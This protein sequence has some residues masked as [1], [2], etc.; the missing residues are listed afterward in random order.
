MK[1]LITGSTG[2]LGSY[3]LKELENPDYKRK[4]DIEKIRLLVRNSEKAKKIKSDIYPIEIVQGDLTDRK[5]IKR[6]VEGIDAV[7]HTASKYNITGKKKDFIQTNVQ[8]TRYLLEELAPGTTFILTSTVGVYGYSANKGKPF[9]EDYEPKRP[10]WHYQVTK[11]MQEDL[12]REMC[13]EKGITFVA[14]RPPMISGAGDEPTRILMENLEKKRIFITRGGKG[15]VP[16]A[17]PIDAARAHLLALEKAKEVNGKAFHFVSF[18]IKFIDFANTFCEKLGLKPVKI[19]APY[20]FIYAFAA[21]MEFLP[22][23]SD[24]SR[25]SVKILGASDT[26]DTTNIEKDLEFKPIKNVHDVVNEA[27]EWYKSLK[28]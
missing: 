19:R 21:F 6:A 4:L 24:F 5:A 25:F 16:V 7:I 2:F 17:H 18:H 10:F 11:K 22:F 13:K 1:L 15:I 20:W 26:L 12:A 3:I 28:K 9:K 23:P 8:G 14:L 27:V